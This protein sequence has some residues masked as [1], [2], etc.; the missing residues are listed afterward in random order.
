MTNIIKDGAN[1][2]GAVDGMGKVKIGKR[3]Y[4]VV[5]RKMGIKGYFEGCSRTIAIRPGLNKRTAAK[6]LLHEI[7]HG[8]I[9]E[10]APEQFSEH[11]EHKFIYPIE[12]G[13][14]EYA[15]ANPNDWLLM[16]IKLAKI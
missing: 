14:A 7:L 16:C 4:R 12:R 1:A 11:E 3:N 9:H 10:Y 5:K 2:T 15:K 8:I 6:T 13:L